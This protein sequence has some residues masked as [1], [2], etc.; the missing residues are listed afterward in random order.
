M[1]TTANRVTGII[2]IGSNTVRLSVYQLTGNG[3]YRVVDQGRWP[4]RLSQRMSADGKLPDEAVEEL[5]EVLRHYV[6]ICAKHGAERVRA[7]A[8]AAIRQAANRDKVAERLRLAAGVDIE[9]LS[10][11]E[12]ARLGS[13]AMLNSLRFGDGFVVDI[14]GGS[15]E[16]TLVRQRKVVSAVSFP[17]GC[18]NVSARYGLGEAVVEQATLN[19]IVAEAKR[20]MQGTD[21]IAGHPGLPLIGLGGTVRA[22]AKLHQ[23]ETGYPFPHL[24]GYE[25]SV[26][27]VAGTLQD[28]AAL[29]VSQRRKRPGLSKDRSDVIVPGLAILR[30]VME[31]TRA[32]SLVVCGTGL[33]DGLFYETC[34]PYSP[35]SSDD[36]VLEESIRNLV[37]LYPAAPGGHL[38]QVRKLA[39][40]LFDPLNAVSPLP[41]G[42]RRLLDTAAR[43]FRIGATIDYNDCADH[44][45]YMLLHTHWN[46]LSHREKILAAAVASYRS[47][48]SLK[49]KLSAYQ[50]MLED[51]DAETIAKLGALLLLA[52]ALDRSESQ[53]ISALHIAI[54]DKKL[55][56]LAESGH[57]LPVERMEVGNMAKEFKKIWGMT[58]DLQVIRTDGA[59][60]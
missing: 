28:L 13:A 60:L 40:A 20:L 45:F 3:A 4:A 19:D 17:I 43:L 58:P 52:S 53:A 51:G 8:T 33:R 26:A 50:S 1:H 32:S 22:A 14:G 31:L 59:P 25:L 55:K 11:E 15:T 41:E 48:S 57:P 5:A 36:D 23:R 18:V 37:A 38:Q 21:W 27:D 16:I 54:E 12:E 29:A 49:R 35:L 30:G 44:T 7:V 24:H 56:L 9:I 46:G 2:D 42:S 47:P 6:R 10:G 39:V 34:H